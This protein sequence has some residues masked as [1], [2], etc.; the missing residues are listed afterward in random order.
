MIYLDSSAVVKLARKEV[1]S[2]ALRAFLDERIV[3]SWGSSALVE[4]EAFRALARHAPSGVGRLARVL[5]L[6]ELLPL[7]PRTRLRAQG[8]QPITVRSLDAIHLATA[9]VHVKRVTSFVSY[10][11]RLNE[12]ASRAGLPVVMPDSP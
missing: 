7:T 8:I 10:D 11:H 9:L 12:A 1:F 6:L 5:D 2:D 4:V 3:S